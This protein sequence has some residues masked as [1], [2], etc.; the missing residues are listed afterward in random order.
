MTIPAVGIAV[1]LMP[2]TVMA[3]PAVGMA[4]AADATDGYGH[5]NRRHGHEAAAT[6]AV[7]AYSRR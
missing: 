2:L 1:G 7:L 6:D 5:S 3:I 4:T